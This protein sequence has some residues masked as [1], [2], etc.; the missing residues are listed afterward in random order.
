MTGGPIFVGGEGRSG[1]TLMRVI[2]DS[3][4]NICCGP[5]THFFIDGKM[6]FWCKHITE[7]Y[8]NRI[9]EY[10]D[11]P[12]ETMA[13]CFG[14]ILSSFH[15]P[16]MKRKNK[17][18]WAD[19][20]PYNIYSIDFLNT[21]FPDM[22][23]IHVIRDGRDVAASMLSMPWGP[24]NIG[25]IATNW[26]S[27]IIIGRKFGTAHKNYLE[28]KYE[29]LI[30]S[31]KPTLMNVFNFLGEPWSEDVL[32]YHLYEHDLGNK[33]SGESSADQVTK[34]IYSHQIGRWKK[35]LTKEQV[36]EFIAIAGNGLLAAGYKID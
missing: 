35:E 5:E 28:V 4:P 22:Q 21:A 18:R 32:N 16:Y 33:Y 7:T 13:R 14:K 10:Y 11:N 20:T 31:F 12:Y 9:L 1:T 15:R 3:H 8:I 25:E 36:D 6:E 34:E 27:C 23:F 24:K 29:D 26:R 30:Y 19:K 2:L 17:V